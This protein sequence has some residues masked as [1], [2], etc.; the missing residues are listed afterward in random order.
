[1]SFWRLGHSITKVWSW[2]KNVAKREICAQNFFLGFIMCP[3]SNTVKRV[4]RGKNKNQGG[5][6]IK[7]KSSYDWYW[8]INVKGLKTSLHGWQLK[9][10]NFLPKIVQE[11]PNVKVQLKMNSNK[12]LPRRWRTHTAPQEWPPQRKE[13]PGSAKC[14]LENFMSVNWIFFSL[15]L[16]FH[17]P[18][19]T[20]PTA[21]THKKEYFKYS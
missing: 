20:A 3:F 7:W 11:N 10:A 14:R 12:L 4:Q 1:M 9:A 17:S 8:K 18:L 19:Y 5:F 21:N 15:K 6:F 13:A 2:F 16:L